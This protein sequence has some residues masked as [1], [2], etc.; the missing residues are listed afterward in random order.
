MSPVSFTISYNLTVI[1]P[2]TIFLFMLYFPHVSSSSTCNF[3]LF[4]LFTCQCKKYSLY[5]TYLLV[6]CL[7][8]FVLL[9]LQKRWSVILFAYTVLIMV[10]HLDKVTKP[11]ILAAFHF[12]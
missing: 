8:I 5:L 1:C 4:P 2:S 9:V 7:M 6:L 11:V 12:L 10:G 3:T